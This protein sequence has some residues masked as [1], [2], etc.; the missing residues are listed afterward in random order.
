MASSFFVSGP[1]PGMNEIVAAA[2]SGRGKGNAYSR[3]KALWTSLVAHAARKA[4]LGHYAAPVSIHCLWREGSARRDPDNIHAG[5][6]FVLDGLVEAGVVS[7]DG[8][9]HIAAVM[10]DVVTVAEN[11]GVT[12]QILSTEAMP[13]T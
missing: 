6:K 4:K 12:I 11:P 3:Q 8:R 7:G 9:R 10:H 5:V 13:K 2:K 1:L